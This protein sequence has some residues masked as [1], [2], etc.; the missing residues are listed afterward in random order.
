MG[1]LDVA[2]IFPM[3]NVER[4]CFLAGKALLRRNDW[5][6][7]NPKRFPTLKCP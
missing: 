1:M 2:V 6:G 5:S 7:L 4:S 3:L